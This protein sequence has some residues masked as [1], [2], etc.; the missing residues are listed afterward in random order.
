MRHPEDARGRKVSGVFVFARK[1][2]A[3]AV[4]RLDPGS[5]EEGWASLQA[6]DERAGNAVREMQ[7]RLPVEPLFCAPRLAVSQLVP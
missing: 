4:A 6:S 2:R 5:A 3:S 1:A 7:T